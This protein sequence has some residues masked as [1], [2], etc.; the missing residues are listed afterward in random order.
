[1]SIKILGGYNYNP[2]N[3][4]NPNKYI[5]K[6][7]V[8]NNTYYQ[9]IKSGVSNGERYTWYYGNFSS[10]REARECRDYWEKLGFPEPPK[11]KKDP[12]RN[13]TKRW[14]HSYRISKSI[15][16]EKIRFGSYP[17]KEYAQYIRDK[18][19]DCG[20][21]KSQLQRIIDEYPKYYT[22]SVLFFK[23][24]MYDP[25]S[26]TGAWKI[27]FSGKKNSKGTY[28]PEYA[29]TCSTL[30][31]A[32]WERDLLLEYGDDHQSY[33]EDTRPNPYKDNIPYYWLTRRP[34]G[35]Q[36]YNDFREE[37]EE[38]KNLI[39]EGVVNQEEMGRVLGVRSV[40]IRNHIKRWGAD[41]KTFKNIVLSG[42]D[43]LEVLEPPT[44]KIIVPDL[45]RYGGKY[46]YIYQHSNGSWVVSKW[47]KTGRDTHYGNYKSKELALKVV[48]ALKKCNWDKSELPRIH[49][50][51]GYKSIVFSKRWVYE[52]KGKDKIYSYSVRHKDK[53][54]KMIN[55]GT[56]KDK[57]V[58]ELVRDELIK[59]DW[60]KKYLDKIKDY[61]EYV[62]NLIDNCYRCKL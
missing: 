32:L 55:Y 56:Y 49:E 14:E 4:I 37:L 9:V 28:T 48:N 61:A 58:A 15:N 39:L 59:C 34:R 46:D 33:A 44:P 6:N 18:L 12:M 7:I 30:E 22:E 62:V 53:N 10:L 36:E 26:P 50:E 40:T 54:K 31:D 38:Y 20:W 19:E 27:I 23:S 57:R 51:L 8:G 3:K 43:P 16:G 45:S 24:I 52:N 1:M 25:N 42:E 17:L 60:D 13:I 47:N 5:H 21:D 11:K 29:L 2:N 41:F 35:K